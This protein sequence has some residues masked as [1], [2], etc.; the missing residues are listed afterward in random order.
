[1]GRVMGLRGRLMAA[2]VLA[3]VLPMAAVGLW[4][5]NVLVDLAEAEHERR[6]AST[7][8]AA[9]D[10]IEQQTRADARALGQLCE[11]DFVVRAMLAR[12]DRAA[13]AG[14][15]E[16]GAWDSR[17]AGLQRALGLEA[18]EVRV[19]SGPDLAAGT[20]L[21]AAPAP[22]RGSERDPALVKGALGLETPFVMRVVTPDAG[23]THAL[24]ARCVTRGEDAAL[25]VL[26]ARKLDGSYVRSLLG[27]VTPV[28]LRAV[29]QNASPG[30]TGRVI[31][32]FI[33]AEGQPAMRVVADL[34]RDPLA[35]DI[36]R[37]DQ[38][39]LVTAAAAVV[40]ALL[41]GGLLGLATTRPLHEL[42]RAAQR[43]G[44]GD[45]E[46]TIGGEHSGEIG[47]A[48]AA[49][50]QMTRELKRTRAKLLRAERIAAW[51]D[52]ARRIAH[53]IKN[54]LSPIQVSIE[55]MRKTYAKG[56]PDFDEIFEESTLAILEEVERLKRIVSE[57]SQFA[58]MP[59]PQAEPIDLR[60][61]A[62]H[63]VG[64]QK[65]G[66]VRVRLS[67]E[68]T[69]VVLGDRE[70]LTQVLSNLVLNA[71]EATRA[72]QMGG[73]GGVRVA[74][75]PSHDGRGAR[76]VVDDSGP[77]V[78][79]GERDRIFEPYYTTKEGGTGLG[80][81]IVHRIVLDHGGEIDVQ[82]SPEGGARFVVSLRPEGPPPE[83]EASFADSAIPLTARK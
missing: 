54:P 64:L 12:A 33:D 20:L 40:L 45:L 22:L 8:V 26:G 81:A 10:R 23:R 51:R 53:E 78:P 13:E 17:A 47:D 70:Q 29:E 9:R 38:G 74:V 67:T 72:R 50:D 83:A 59:R 21:A 43:V 27:D 63:V 80:L 55:T 77:G 4:A 76:V 79:E 31:H 5:R 2:F 18:V 34:G 32:T 68:P 82:A 52:I 62:E 11:R 48:L 57:F 6:I 28:E 30:D 35:A 15:I 66:P 42:E 19:V 60:D 25:T 16:A 49:F 58:R 46:S 36:A 1:M 37:L 61:V 44:S 41:V 71:M 65:E 69:P 3:A 39:L 7:V 14:P 73:D 24:V 56:H 75:G